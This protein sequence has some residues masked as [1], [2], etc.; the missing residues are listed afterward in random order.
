MRLFSHKKQRQLTLKCFPFD[1]FLFP[2]LEERFDISHDFCWQG[3][4][5]RC[6]AFLPPFSCN[7]MP[8]LILIG[9]RS[10]VLFLCAF[11]FR[12]IL[13]FC[14][15]P[16]VK[17]YLPDNS[18]AVT[19]SKYIHFSVLFEYL[20]QSCMQQQ[21]VSSFSVVVTLSVEVAQLVQVPGNKRLFTQ[22]SCFSSFFTL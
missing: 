11:T 18:F 4:K 20:E 9:C 2:P 8:R 5:R 19:I 6:S 12:H 10:I 14:L 13:Y 22:G 3:K 16:K 1:A 17:R 21:S 7:L 15:M